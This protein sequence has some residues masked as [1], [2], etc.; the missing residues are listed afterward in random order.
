MN[1]AQSQDA[2]ITPVPNEGDIGAALQ[3]F[4]Q[5]TTALD[6][7][8]S[9]LQS[10]DFAA[11]RAVTDKIRKDIDTIPTRDENTRLLL[12][13]ADNA[14]K[15]HAAMT[16]L[17][18]RAVEH[19]KT[20]REFF[21]RATQDHFRIASDLTINELDQFIANSTE[22]LHRFPDGWRDHGQ[23]VPFRFVSALGFTLGQ[24][25]ANLA[26]TDEGQALIAAGDVQLIWVLSSDLW[27]R[28]AR[29][30]DVIAE[31]EAGEATQ[32]APNLDQ[33]TMSVVL[34]TVRELSNTVADLRARLDDREAADG[35]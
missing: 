20:C 7:Y 30:H 31:R 18:T 33:P 34:E 32:P 28:F 24:M 25:R 11:F 4:M 26:A 21:R 29:I 16:A 9:D 12:I 1:N 35:E 5:M 8:V 3:N 15:E 14:I 23:I 10:F 19:L 22:K 27:E 6:A 2:A 17:T 13:E